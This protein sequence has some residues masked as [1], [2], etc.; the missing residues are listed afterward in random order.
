MELLLEL[1]KRLHYETH[2]PGDYV[3]SIGDEGTLF[4]VILEGQVGIE[5]PYNL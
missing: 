1:C 2:G 3:F 4:Y 5:M